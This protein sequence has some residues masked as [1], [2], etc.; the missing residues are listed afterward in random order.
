MELSKA[1]ISM[2][3]LSK[4]LLLYLCS[5]LDIPELLLISSVSK[6]LLGAS[7]KILHDKCLILMPNS[8]NENTRWI[9]N[10]TDLTS[11]GKF[12]TWLHSNVTIH[13]RKTIEKN[14]GG[15]DSNNVFIEKKIF[16]G[17]A[18]VEFQINA[19][20]DEMAIGVTAFPSVIRNVNAWDNVGHPLEFVY[21]RK[22]TYYGMIGLGRYKIPGR[23]TFSV[24]DI[25]TIYINA[26]ERRVNWYRNKIFVGTNLP[27]SPL[28]DTTEGYGIWTMV[29]YTNDNVMIWNYGYY[30][31][32]TE[33]EEEITAW[34]ELASKREK[35]I[36]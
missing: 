4:D 6:T 14:H 17:E 29:D 5:F 28:P 12:E 27:E 35:K 19:S 3:S 21:N 36:R 22:P 1:R 32:Y 9:V 13:N 7:E 24:G 18:F 2:E 10:Y 8:N 16:K 26:D 11:L 20:F 34:K 15:W 31:P 23:N 33:T 25:V 30:K